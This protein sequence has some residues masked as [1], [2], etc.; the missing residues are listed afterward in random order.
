VI[1]NTAFMWIAGY[2]L[3]MSEI[4][5]GN[6]PED[7]LAALEAESTLGGIDI[8]K[9]STA[10]EQQAKE[11]VDAPQQPRVD[12]V[13]A[14]EL[15]NRRVPRKNAP[16]PDKTAAERVKDEINERTKLAMHDYFDDG[17]N[18]LLERFESRRRLKEGAETKFN[19]SNAG[20]LKLLHENGY[21]SEE[22]KDAQQL[23][24]VAVAAA[25]IIADKDTPANIKRHLLGP[26][27]S[28][29]REVFTE[30]IRKYFWNKMSEAQTDPA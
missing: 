18:A 10:S 25:Q 12:I 30:E 3:D 19:I 17:V 4:L 6:K 1:N 15:A 29:A 26:S 27:S 7:E 20:L 21:I 22:M 24:L 5:T 9:I 2:S 8:T 14:I 28:L 13:K 16:R 11:T 23:D